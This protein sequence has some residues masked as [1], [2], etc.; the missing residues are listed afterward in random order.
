[1]RITTHGS[2]CL[3]GFALSEV[4]ISIAVS[5]LSVAA[6]VSSS[7][8]SARSA[9]WISHSTAADASAGTRMEQTRAAKWDTAAT[10]VID[11][12]V[13]GNFPSTVV[14]LYVPVVGGAMLYGTNRVTISQVADAPPL[15]MV[16]VECVWSLPERG[17][18]TNS[19]VMYRSPDQ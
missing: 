3:R 12:L 6:V 9:D 1:M 2:Q 17:P 11:E 13:N 15:K 8:L 7:V 5:A 14:P 10:P 19:V 16:Q 18:F 4:V